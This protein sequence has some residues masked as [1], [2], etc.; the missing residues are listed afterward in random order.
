[1]DTKNILNLNILDINEL[2]KGTSNNLRYVKRFSTCR[3]TLTESVAEHSFYT[4]LYSLFIAEYC[5]YRYPDSITINGVYHCV[6]KALMHDIEE[7][8]TGDIVRPVKHHDKKLGTIMNAYSYLVLTD[9]FQR[10]TDR[11][12]IQNNLFNYWKDAKSEDYIGRIVTFADVLSVIAYL[13]QE[14]NGGNSLIIKNT[15]SLL[16]YFNEKFRTDDYSFIKNLVDQAYE[17]LNELNTGDL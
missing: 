2:V 5:L 17:V 6:V 3:T 14:K 9:F 13:Y 15:V 4:A 7:Q 1:M 10:I 16:T 8:Y 12:T 11:S